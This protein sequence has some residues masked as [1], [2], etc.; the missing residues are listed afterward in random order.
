MVAVRD[1]YA[2]REAEVLIDQFGDAALGLAIKRA[3]DLAERGDRHGAGIWEV[4]AFAVAEQKLGVR[5]R[6]NPP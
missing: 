4:I 2:W 3:I 6:A 1:D 5:E